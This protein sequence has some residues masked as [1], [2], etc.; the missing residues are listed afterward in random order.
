MMNVPL[1][2]IRDQLLHRA[3]EYGRFLAEQHVRPS[4]MTGWE[5][6]RLSREQSLDFFNEFV[7]PTGSRYLDREYRREQS[8]INS[9]FE[10]R[11]RAVLEDEKRFYGE[12]EAR[13]NEIADIA[14]YVGHVL[15]PALIFCGRKAA[16]IDLADFTINRVFEI[17]S[18]DGEGAGENRFL[19]ILLF[20]PAWT[21]AIASLAV[22]ETG[23]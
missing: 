9:A 3:A 13:E 17:V 12:V 15:V 10:E 6:Y 8:E 16:A 2:T 11:V 19:F 5:G 1:E 22:L 4:T 7:L 23:L 21:L 18:R 20:L 14:I